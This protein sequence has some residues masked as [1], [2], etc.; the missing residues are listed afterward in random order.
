MTVR[1]VSV[2]L[3]ARLAGVRAAWRW[4]LE[5][6]E[7]LRVAAEAGS[8]AAAVA[9]AGEVI[10]ADLMFDDGT[11]ADLCAGSR[12]VVVVTALPADERAEVDLA[13]ASAVLRTGRV[14][15]GLAPAILEAAGA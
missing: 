5:N 8:V 11:A 1:V 7:G 12:P 4:V 3:A 14:R 13:A 9:A 2:V 6:E 15:R 10:V